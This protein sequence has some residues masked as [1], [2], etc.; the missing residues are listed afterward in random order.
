ALIVRAQSHIG[1]GK[2][3]VLFTTGHLPPRLA[4]S[5]EARYQYLLFFVKVLRPP[6]FIMRC[7]F[8]FQGYKSLNRMCSTGAGKTNIAMIAILHEVSF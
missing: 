8:A 6:K 7:I 4:V 5:L 2:A 1:V 3:P